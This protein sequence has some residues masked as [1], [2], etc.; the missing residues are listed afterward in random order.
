MTL[1]KPDDRIDQIGKQDPEAKDNDHRA[2]NVRECK[3]DTPFS[4][5]D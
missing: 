5:V 3:L 4:H 2:S 1:K